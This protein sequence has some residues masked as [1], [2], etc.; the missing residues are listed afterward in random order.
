MERR[1]FTMI[2]VVLVGV[3]VGVGIVSKQARDP[4]LRQI[5]Q[6][7][8]DIIEW[9]NEI[10]DQ[11]VPAQ[12]L[13]AAGSPQIASLIQTQQNLEARIAALETKL[14]TLQQA[15]GNAQQ[16]PPPEDLSKVYDIAA[17]HSPIKGVKNA[18]VTIVEFVDFQCPFCA[19]FHPPV[20]EVLKAYPKDVNLM[21]KNFPLNFH[22]E[23]RP[24]AKAAFAA[25]E[26]GKYWEMVD[27][28]LLS[29]RELSEAKYKELA[30]QLGLDIDR[31]L[32]DFKGKDAQ[33]EDYIEKDIA[34]G[35]QVNV[36]GT[37]TFYIN[38][39]KTNARDFESLKS[40]IDAILK[41]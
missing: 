40:E 13:G 6:N 28:L 10:E 3:L 24:A 38:G 41:Q 39:R 29:G 14:N 7:Q 30:G 5:V 12:G 16:G 37:P 21:V 11:I 20:S 36:R 31:F 8:N 23:A 35:A 15:G 18:P 32:K 25:G 9:Q 17:A 34:L 19:R 27:A 22:P 26:Q 33:W 4:L 2:L 1:I